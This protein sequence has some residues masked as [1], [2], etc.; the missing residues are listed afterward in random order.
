[1]KIRIM[2]GWIIEHDY[3][4]K[5]VTRIF[6][7]TGEELYEQTGQNYILMSPVKIYKKSILLMVVTN[8]E[9]HVYSGNCSVEFK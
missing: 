5:E 3:D 1:M 6:V 9:H 8:N 2:D 4:A 7:T